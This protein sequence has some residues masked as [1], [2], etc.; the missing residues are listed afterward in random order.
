MVDTLKYWGYIEQTADSQKYTLGLKV[1]ELGMAKLQRLDFFAE[2]APYLKKLAEK[3]N[4]TVNLGVLDSGEVV[5]LDKEESTRTVKAILYPG[6]RAPIHCTAIGKVLLAFQPPD[7]QAN[8]IKGK[9]LKKYNRNTITSWK[10][11]NEELKKI[12]NFGYAF[13]DGEQIEEVN[14]VAV[15]IYDVNGKVIAAI[16]VSVPAFRMNSEKKED[17]ISTSKKI[18]MEISM[19]LGYKVF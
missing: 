19:R 13:D 18:A 15:P 9:K 6:R 12:K 14:C 17:V 3:F 2:S 1:V 10:E 5:Y 11:L 16:S 8:I 7:V 4:E